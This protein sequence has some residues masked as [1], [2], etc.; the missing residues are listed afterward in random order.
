MLKFSEE[1]LGVQS[2]CL[3]RPTTGPK[4]SRD[5]DCK[6]EQIDRKSVTAESP[7]HAIRPRMKRALFFSDWY[8]SSVKESCVANLVHSTY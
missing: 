4:R 3:S 1:E 2:E 7:S 6:S 8:K 5:T